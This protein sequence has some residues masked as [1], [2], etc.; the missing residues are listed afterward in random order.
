[1]TS[2]LDK[3]FDQYLWAV[4]DPGAMRAE[5]APIRV[6]I[7]DDHPIYIDGLAAAIKRADDLE[8]VAT[9]RDG[10]E[11]LERIEAE[12]PDVAVLDLRMPRMKTT[13]ILEELSAVDEHKCRVLVLSVHVGASEVHECVSLGAAGYLAKDTDR[14]EICDAIRAVA[15]GRTVLSNDAQT[16]MAQELM[17][18]R[19]AARSV[20]SGREG[21]VLQLLASGASAPDIA[22]QL[23]LSIATVKTHLHNLYEKLEVSDRAAAVAEGMRRGLIS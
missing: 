11:A 22:A 7:A 15:Q 4:R 12:K 5:A 18:R 1:M 21:Q 6:L 10:A 3:P 20:L 14:A 23:H 2:R 19:S 13:A 16:A 17:R 8:L 9:A